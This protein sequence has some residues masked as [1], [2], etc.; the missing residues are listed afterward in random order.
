MP[1]SVIWSCQSM[2]LVKTKIF[3]QS[4][5]ICIKSADMISYFVI[6]ITEVT[7]DFYSSATIQ[8]DT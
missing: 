4:V 1:V 2:T 8:N 3:L 7:N 5:S 6:A